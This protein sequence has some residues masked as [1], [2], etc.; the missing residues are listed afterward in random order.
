MIK[1]IYRAQFSK[2][3]GERA[4]VGGVSGT[5]GFDWKIGPY[6][7]LDNSDGE[8]TKNI[9]LGDEVVIGRKSFLYID[10]TPAGKY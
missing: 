8:P 7:V 6:L 5:L 3:T 2:L 9:F 10:G 4:S 1:T